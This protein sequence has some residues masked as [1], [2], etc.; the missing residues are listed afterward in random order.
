[1]ATFKKIFS[2]LIFIIIHLIQLGNLR[3]GFPVKLV[4]LSHQ[5]IYLQFLFRFIKIILCHFY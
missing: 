5:H 1:M 4:R 2:F 3:L